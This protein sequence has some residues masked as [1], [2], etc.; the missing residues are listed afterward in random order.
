MFE[1][2]STYTEENPYIVAEY[3]QSS[4]MSASRCF[5]DY[6]CA[7]CDMFD[8]MKMSQIHLY[9]TEMKKKISHLQ[10]RHSEVF[11]AV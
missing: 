3:S 5:H 1:Y 10:K 7:V 6:A 8:F 4:D 11:K 2:A 9:Y